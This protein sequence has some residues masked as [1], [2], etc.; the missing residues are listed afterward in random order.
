MKRRRKVA[1]VLCMVSVAFVLAAKARVADAY[2][3]NASDFATSVVNYVKGNGVGSDWISGASFDNTTAALGRPTV[4]TT[5]DGWFISMDSP[6]P[7]VP[8]YAPSRAFEVVTIGEGGSLTVKFD[9]QVH[10][11][12]GNPYGMDFTIFGNAFQLAG[13]ADGW[14]NGDPTKITMTSTLFANPAT[15]SVSKD[16]TTWFTFS[17]GPEASGFAP[18]LGRVYDPAHPDGS[19]GAWNQWWGV[20]TDPTVPLD[21]TATSL[22]LGGLTVA[23][24][25]QLY[26]DSAGGTSFDIGGLGLDW[27][28]Y[29][30][31]DVPSGASAVTS[32]DAFAD[33]AAVPEPASMA[34][35]LTGLGA[36]AARVRRHK[37]R[38]SDVLE[39]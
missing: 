26:G 36:A 5:G 28:Q 24:A 15:V 4:D 13:G 2:N 9:H 17:S 35:F 12:P 8:C 37:R 6:V 1:A 32:V 30:R 21:P 20:P 23:Q 19:I 3:Y 16:G 39:N 38:L 10:N 25:A 14:S 27:I 34:L 7:V 33:V 22:S 29:V 18:T 31:I 11:D